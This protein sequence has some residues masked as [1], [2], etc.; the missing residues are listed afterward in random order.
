MADVDFHCLVDNTLH[1]GFDVRGVRYYNYRCGTHTHDFVEMN[2]VLAGSG[3][4]DIQNCR[5]SVKA[6]DVFVIPPLVAHSYTD[7]KDLDVYHLL[8]HKD[9]ILRNQEEAYQ[10]KG[11]L[12]LTEIEPFLRSNINEAFFLHLSRS[13]LEQLESDLQLIDDESEFTWEKHAPMKYHTT[14]KILYW[15]S[16]LLHEQITSSGRTKVDKNEVPV[17][18]ALDYIHRHFDERITIEGLCEKA[19]LSRSTFLRSFQAV[20]GTSPIEYLNNYRCQKALE[21]LEMT[22]RSKTEIAHS[23]GFYDLS[24]MKRMLKK[25]GGIT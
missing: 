17:I 25:V 23:C 16:G 1:S 22:N 15:L 18:R 21:L 4:H 13:K 9:F 2:I 7:T 12:Q 14:W 8:W 5:F 3:I 10:V 24:H 6:G 20:C 11:F 19:Y